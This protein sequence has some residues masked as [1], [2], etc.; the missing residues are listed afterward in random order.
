MKHEVRLKKPKKSSE[1]QVLVIVLLIATICLIIVAGLALRTAR[2]IREA[3]RARE[4]QIAYG[5]ALSG[6]EAMSAAISEGEIDGQPLENCS[7]DFPCELSLAGTNQGYEVSVYPVTNDY[8]DIAKDRAIDLWLP[9][10]NS[11][12]RVV[13]ECKTSCAGE[14]PG[15]S[16]AIQATVISESA[17][18]YEEERFTLSCVSGSVW[19]FDSCVLPP[20]G[21]TCSGINNI[22]L[23]G[24]PR[25]VR[26]KAFVDG[27][28]CVSAYAAA[29]TLGGEIVSA[30]GGYRIDSNGY[31]YDGVTSTISVVL[32]PSGL[33]YPFDF[34]LYD[35]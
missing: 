3:R 24:T 31:G 33:P 6:L 17:G 4:Y 18:S 11:A 35:G 21:T 23:G 27:G 20:G 16:K 8:I 12:G 22:A 10:G 30:T 19:G 13:L 2:R 32:S 5:Q 14:A 28:S 15:V 29:E 9:E 26:V 34:S 7:L 25:L 1:G